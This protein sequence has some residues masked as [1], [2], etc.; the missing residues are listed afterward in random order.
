MKR[1]ASGRSEGAW[2]LKTIAK[3]CLRNQWQ[4]WVIGCFKLF[5]EEFKFAN[6]LQQAAALNN[7]EVLE[8]SVLKWVITSKLAVWN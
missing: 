2:M 7:I 8:N 3:Y 1:A 4:N 5:T 6:A